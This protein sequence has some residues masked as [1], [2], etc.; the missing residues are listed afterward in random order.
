MECQRQFI[1]RLHGCF[2][3]NLRN[4]WIDSLA[5]VVGNETWRFGDNYVDDA[6]SA[7]GRD[8]K[9]NLE[10]AALTLDN[11]R[12]DF[13]DSFGLDGSHRSRTVFGVSN[14]PVDEAARHTD[15]RIH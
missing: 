2:R 5:L 1:H 12:H 13:A 11:I 10:I 3:K 15:A 6:E 9:T 14:R 7:A 8:F 4:L